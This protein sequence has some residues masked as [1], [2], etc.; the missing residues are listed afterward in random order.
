M[1]E[2][3]AVCK[4]IICCAMAM[5]G[6]HLA[7]ETMAKSIKDELVIRTFD[8]LYE[9][10]AIVSLPG[11]KF[12]IFEDE[13]REMITS[14]SMGRNDSGLVLKKTF[15]GGA[16]LNVTDIEGAALGAGEQ[17]FIVTSHSTR[18]DGKRNDRRERLLRLKLDE[19]Q[20]IRI[21]GQS[22]LRE[23]MVQE[24][25]KAD[26]VLAEKEDELNIEG[27]SFT[28][29]KKL[30]IGLRAPLAKNK[31]VLLQ[32]ENPYDAREKGFVPKFSAR[33]FLLDLGGGGVR[34]MAFNEK[35]GLYF[36]VSETENKKGKMKSRLWSW[37]G[38]RKEAPLQRDFSDLKHLH[39]IEG[40]AFFTYEGQEMLL[41][42]CDDG[43]KKKKQGAHYAII[44]AEQLR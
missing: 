4:V 17:F 16:D 25:L 9:P 14:F 32:L 38:D 33:P 30:M 24:L 11:G 23:A 1:E 20:Q 43:N 5:V 8:G 12:L 3:V 41:L 6:T 21:Q 44:A 13:G 40:L 36:F 7:K 31:A 27:L 29:D 34:A 37:S 18:K 15:S 35:Q 10:S 42:V 28:G 26:S 39:N 2:I 19:N 22:N